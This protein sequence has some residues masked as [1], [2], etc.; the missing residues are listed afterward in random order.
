MDVGEYE[1]TV[2]FGNGN[3][4]PVNPSATLVVY[5]RVIVIDEELL[6]T[7]LVYNGKEQSPVLRVSNLVEGD[8]CEIYFTGDTGVNAG[9]YQITITGLSNSN[10]SIANANLTY[11]I[12]KFELT[13]DNFD[14]PSMIYD[15]LIFNGEEQ[16]LIGSMSQFIGEEYAEM[17]DPYTYCIK[18]SEDRLIELSEIPTAVN[19][20]DYYVGIMLDTD[21]YCGSAFANSIFVTVT[22]SGIP[23]EYIRPEEGSL[24]EFVYTGEDQVVTTAHFEVN[25]ITIDDYDALEN[26]YPNYDFSNLRESVPSEEYYY[27]VRIIPSSDNLSELYLK[28]SEDNLYLCFDNDC[29]YYVMDV[30]GDNSRYMYTSWADSYMITINPT[31]DEML[32]QMNH[33]YEIRKDNKDNKNYARVIEITP[34]T[35]QNYLN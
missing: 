9:D 2:S 33:V 29:Y 21:N 10:Y 26:K 12:Q 18:D 16:P 11:T 24:V 19:V 32:V 30:T 1:F 5:P 35:Y 17:P 23:V 25:G 13:L 4:I 7:G 22:I 3:Y 8:E 28:E 20:G 6:N 31:T 27:G 14:A 15:N 34:D